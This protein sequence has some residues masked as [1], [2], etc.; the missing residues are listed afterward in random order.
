MLIFAYFKFFMSRVQM[1]I[2]FFGDNDVFIWYSCY[3][4]FK[5]SNAMNFNILIFFCQTSVK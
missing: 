1:I 2:D 4:V 3:D 5:L